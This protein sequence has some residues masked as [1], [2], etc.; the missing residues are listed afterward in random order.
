MP[1]AAATEPATV[2]AALSPHCPPRPWSPTN[3]RPW[4]HPHASPRLILSESHHRGQVALRSPLLVNHQCVLLLVTHLLYLSPRSPAPST[5]RHRW[6]PLLPPR[7]PPCHRRLGVTSSQAGHRSELTGCHTTQS[8]SSVAR[9]S[10]QAAV[11]SQGVK[12]SPP[13]QALGTRRVAH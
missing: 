10:P 4:S 2:C 6:E 12:P 5:Q 7:A 11:P 1:G 9:T 8:A 3:Y 13:P